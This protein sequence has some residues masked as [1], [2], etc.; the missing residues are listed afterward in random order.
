M[1]VEIPDPWV[2]LSV[3]L[4]FFVGLAALH[5]FY[6]VRP[7][8][9]PW[10]GESGMPDGRL[11]YY[12]RQLIDMK[13][14]LDAMEIQ[15]GDKTEDAGVE[16]RQ[17]LERL[18]GGQMP[19]KAEEPRL[20]PKKTEPVRQEPP[21]RYGSP[22]DH[23]LHLITDRA[24][25]SRDIQVTLGKSR[26]HTSRLMKRLFE[27]GLVERNTDA[28]PYTYSI[29]DKGRARGMERQIGPVAA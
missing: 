1:L 4:A 12:E 5:A 26:E 20:V 29:T 23:V 14:R 24:M 13:I 19:E 6:R 25:T 9:G 16:I 27:E 17:L 10:G 18:A 2:I 21:P 3:V 8:V 22:T 15:G 7:R 11:E 28:K